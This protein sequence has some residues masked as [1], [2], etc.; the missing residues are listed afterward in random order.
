MPQTLRACFV[1]PS[2]ALD[3]ERCRL[4]VESRQACAP[5]LDHY[6]VVDRPD[7]PLFRALADTRT[8]IVDSRELLD[9]ELHKLWGGNGWWFGKRV[10][11]LRGWIT[12]QLRKLAMP[13]LT[14]CAVLINLDSDV[15]FTRP[16]T[17]D[18]LFDGDKLGL[19]EVDYRND[20]ICRWS[21]KAAALTGLHS[22]TVPN[23]YVGMMIGWWSRIVNDLTDRIEH[24]AGLPW[25]VAL[26]RCHSFSEYMTYGTFVRCGMGLEAAGH[27]SDGRMLV[28]TSWHRDTA[29]RAELERLFAQTSDDAVAVMVHSKDGIAPADYAAFAR[30]NWARS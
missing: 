28:Q 22:P 12:Q 26:A 27:F 2:Y 25:Q 20:E 18:R 24:R 21:R 8:R 23:N 14:D 7:L 30:R 1:T 3:F 4:L 11:P 6:I 15:V 5:E 17:L 29:N 16:F 9:D 19:F 13:R 10:P